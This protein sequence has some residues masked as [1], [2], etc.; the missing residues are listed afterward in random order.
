MVK[1]KRYTDDFRASVVLMLKAAG[2]PDKKGSLTQVANRVK[3]PARTISRWYKKENNPP[4][5]I[6][7]KEKSGEMVDRLDHIGRLLLDEMESAIPDAPLRELATAYGITF[8]KHQLLTGGPTDNMNQSIRF[9]W[10]T[11][12]NRND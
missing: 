3:A 4:P 1:H 7:V 5:D 2:Y 8:D 6:L 10:A 12:E 9:V 11:D